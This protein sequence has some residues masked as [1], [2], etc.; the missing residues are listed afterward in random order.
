MVTAPQQNWSMYES[1]S[2][3]ENAEWIRSL[4]P[5]ERFVIYSGLFNAVWAARRD[6]EEVERLERWRWE[7]K[8]AQR[9]RAVEAFE[10]LD[11][12]RRERSAANNAG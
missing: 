5:T 6:P 3:K 4:S 8:L 10:K 9:M 12:L 1:L 11:E 7:Q 2:R